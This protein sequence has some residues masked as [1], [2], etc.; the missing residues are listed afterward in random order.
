VRLR[1]ALALLDRLQPAMRA[2]N[3]ALQVDIVRQVVALDAPLGPQWQ[4]LADLALQQ[5]ELALARQ[6]MDRFVDAGGASPAALYR[7]A[8]LLEQCGDAAAAHALLRELPEDVPDA[9]TNAY[10]RGALALFMGDIG[11][12]RTQLERATRLRPE[13]GVPWLMLATLLDMAQEPDLAERL[14]AA[15]RRVADSPPAVRAPYYHAA[16]KVQADRGEHALAF[17]AF[18]RAA[19]EMK[20]LAPYRAEADRRNAEEAV[21]GYGPDGVSVLSGRQQASSRETIFVTGLPRSGTTLV[22]Q[23]LVSHND[24]SDGA[25]LNRLLLL[26]QDIGGHSGEA[27]GAYVEAGGAAEAARLWRHWMDERFPLPGIVVDK[28][29]TT[30]RLLGIAAALLPEARLV[31]VTRDP[32]DC[33]W[34]CFR[35][36]LSGYMPWTHDLQDMAHHFRVEEQLLERWQEKLGDR[37]L[38]VPYEALASKPQ[39]SIPQLLAHCGLAVEDQVYRPHET[40]RVVTTAS[41]LKVRQP[42]SN[43]AIGSAEPY[44]EFLGAFI[45]AYSS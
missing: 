5:G 42:I 28:S 17:A 31:W 37:L 10:S 34:S 27:V 9:A 18:A 8:L 30:T 15:G 38:V 6:A 20:T 14:L 40:A 19:A 36:F 29:L 33:A 26:S 24:V 44:R 2:R 41:A 39:E 7:K 3:R 4:A 22:E 21:R 16:G 11:E 45:E 1:D 25:E 32:L 12:A 43:A 35:T 23:I 13:A